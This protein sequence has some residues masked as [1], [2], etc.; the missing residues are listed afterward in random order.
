MKTKILNRT[1]HDLRA[2]SRK[3]VNNRDP[4]ERPRLTEDFLHA[5]RL[6]NGSASYADRPDD[7]AESYLKNGVG[8]PSRL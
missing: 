1:G 7:R 4:M 8:K 6:H 3:L 5:E 2:T